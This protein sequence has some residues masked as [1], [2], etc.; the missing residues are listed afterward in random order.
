MQHPVSISSS[1][2]SQGARGSSSG[3]PSLFQTARGVFGAGPRKDKQPQGQSPRESWLRPAPHSKS[4]SADNSLVCFTS[5]RLR[6]RRS[7]V[8]PAVHGLVGVFNGF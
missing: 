5:E 2:C 6:A 7:H 1:L 8:L 3:R 4:K